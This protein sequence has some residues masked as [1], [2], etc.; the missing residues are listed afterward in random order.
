MKVTL[1][2]KINKTLD[3]MKRIKS[4]SNIDV[5]V[6]IP[7]ENAGR[8]D[9]EINNAQLMAYHTKGVRAKSMRKEM[10]KTMESGINYDVAYSMYI[11]SFGSPIWHIPPRPIIE[12]AIVAS[13]NKEAIAE[14]L[15]IAGKFMLEGEKDKA[16]A[17]LHTAG[18]DAVNRIRLWFEDPRNNWPKLA[19]STKAAK[20]SNAILVDTSQMK[21]AISYVVDIKG[22]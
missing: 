3:V 17:A 1:K 12:P 8:N 4:I 20:G 6:G 11:T 15:K 21:K 14:D 22:E 19:D 10:N 16:I 18:I 13:G 2:T 7:E 5:L 9:G